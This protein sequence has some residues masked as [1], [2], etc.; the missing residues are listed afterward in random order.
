MWQSKRKSRQEENVFKQFDKT[1]DRLAALE[2][3]LFIAKRQKTA[4]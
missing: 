2:A 3:K 1:M 4:K